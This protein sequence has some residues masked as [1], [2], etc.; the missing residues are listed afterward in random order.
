[1]FSTEGTKMEDI[2]EMYQKPE[3]IEALQRRKVES[4]IRI[5]E[6]LAGMNLSVLEIENVLR[7]CGLNNDCAIRFG[8]SI[9]AEKEKNHNHGDRPM[10]P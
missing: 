7:T 10:H 2:E 8:V 6:E 5:I 4:L 9:T 1:M 3:A